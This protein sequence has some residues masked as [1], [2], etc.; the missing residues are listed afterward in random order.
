MNESNTQNESQPSKP[1]ESP[2][3]QPVK[4]TNPGRVVERQNNVPLER[5]ER[6]S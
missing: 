2:A 1:A 4:P 3:P 6:H 5:K